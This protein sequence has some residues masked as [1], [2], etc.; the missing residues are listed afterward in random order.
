MMELR[1]Q[2]CW[3]CCLFG[4]RKE[5]S[6]E[7]NRNTTVLVRKSV[8]SAAPCGLFVEVWRRRVSGE[9]RETPPR[10]SWSSFSRKATINREPWMLIVAFFFFFAAQS[11]KIMWHVLDFQTCGLHLMA[12]YHLAGL[13]SVWYMH[14]SGKRWCVPLR[15]RSPVEGYC[16]P[17][18][19]RWGW[20]FGSFLE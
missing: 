20:V 17:Y 4:V 13:S 10:W 9:R 15:Q 19:R 8:S 6:N 7:W 2:P 11:G 18:R 1:W 12:R 5:P 14:C 3:G 16:R